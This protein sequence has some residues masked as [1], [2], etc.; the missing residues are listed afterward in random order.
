V[1]EDR[2]C[3]F[4]LRIEATISTGVFVQSRG[5]GPLF[6]IQRAWVAFSAANAVGAFGKETEIK[7][8]T[9][10]LVLGRLL[11]VTVENFSGL[12]SSSSACYLPVV[13][14]SGYER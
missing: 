13:A 14:H 12:V 6:T 4:E 8:S 5:G 7:R 3:L 2:H 9:T 10:L 11:D 1:G